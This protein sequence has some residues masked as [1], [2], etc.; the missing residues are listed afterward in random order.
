ML[1]RSKHAAPRPG[2]GC[3]RSLRTGTPIRSIRCRIA[4]TIPAPTPS[5]NASPAMSRSIAPA[6]PWSRHACA[7]GGC[8]V[9]SSSSLQPG[10][11][12][13]ALSSGEPVRNQMASWALIWR[14]TTFGETANAQD[15]SHL[16]GHRCNGVDRTSSSGGCSGAPAGAAEKSAPGV[17]QAELTDISA[18]RRIHRGYAR[19]HYR[20][21]YSRGY[22]APYDAYAYDPYYRPYYRPGFSV[23]VGP[24]GF[25][26]GF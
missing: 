5:A 21:Y 1:R 25:G 20:P 22:Y 13:C 2:F 18:A 15:V 12:A 19:H 17:K 11:A 7:A 6:A 26:F 10:H 9:K 24:F 4:S 3:A 8:G 16:C 14:E 23:G